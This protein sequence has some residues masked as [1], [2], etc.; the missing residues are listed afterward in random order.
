MIIDMQFRNKYIQKEFQTFKIIYFC[1]SKIK[2][3]KKSP[4]TLS[5]ITSGKKYTVRWN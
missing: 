5:I 4:S 3:K 2:L 1:T